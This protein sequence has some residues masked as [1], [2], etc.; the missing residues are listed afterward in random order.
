[1]AGDANATPALADGHGLQVS[2]VRQLDPRLLE[3][4]LTTDALP[5]PAHVR[6][7]LPEGYESEPARR[8]PV[9]YLLTGTEGSASDWTRE[10]NTERNTV[11][12]GVIV[13]MP[14]VALDRDGG[15]WCTNWVNAG[16]K[17]LPEW[18]RFHIGQLIPWV[19]QDLRSIAA[20]S[21]R[22]IAG[23]SQ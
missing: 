1:M 20:R 11:G 19:D 4:T 2:A 15:G 10:K 14:D 16:A 12:Q 23:L 21:G 13:V 7:L 22:A 5:K 9:L 8:Y 3:A 17:G 18:E 6:I